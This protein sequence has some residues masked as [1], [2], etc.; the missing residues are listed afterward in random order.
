[1]RRNYVSKVTVWNIVKGRPQMSR[2]RCLLTIQKAWINPI[3]DHAS[4]HLLGTQ[5]LL[6]F[7]LLVLGHASFLFFRAPGAVLVIGITSNMFEFRLVCL[8]LI[9]SASLSGLTTPLFAEYFCYLVS[10]MHSDV[11]AAFDSQI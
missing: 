2:G 6:K 3:V 11:S 7:E 4:S 5:P 10:D 8:R 1:M 9:E